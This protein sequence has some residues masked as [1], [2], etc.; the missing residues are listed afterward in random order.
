MNNGESIVLHISRYNDRTVKLHIDIVS[1]VAEYLTICDEKG[2]NKKTDN[3][4]FSIS[5]NN[6]QFYSETISNSKIKEIMKTDKDITEFDYQG[7]GY[8]GNIKQNL[9]IKNYSGHGVFDL[10][11]S[12]NNILIRDVKC[13]VYKINVVSNNSNLKDYSNCDYTNTQPNV[14]LYG[15]FGNGGNG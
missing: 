2:I 5:I 4:E 14:Y 10:K 9:S 8:Y 7:S 11:L 13:D 12:I 3:F 6:N 1:L 15:V